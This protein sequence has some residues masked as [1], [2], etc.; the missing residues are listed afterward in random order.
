MNIFGRTNGL[1]EFNL[2]RKHSHTVRS[3]VTP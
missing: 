2:T 1:K 3:A